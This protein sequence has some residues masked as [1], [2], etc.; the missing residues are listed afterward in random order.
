MVNLFLLQGEL[1]ECRIRVGTLEKML[2][3]KELQLLDLQEHRGALQAERDGL[4]GEL[5]DLRSQHCSALKEAQE[6]A[7]RMVV[8]GLPSL[9]VMFF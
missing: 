7:H 1:G 8:R 5:Q 6:Q 3:Q 9:Q 4:K 2:A